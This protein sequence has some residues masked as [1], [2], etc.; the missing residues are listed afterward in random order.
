MTD[1]WKLKYTFDCSTF[2]QSGNFQ[3]HE[4]GG[5]D[6][7]WSVNDPAKSKSALTH[8]YDDAGSH[9]LQVNSEY[10]WTMKVI[11]ERGQ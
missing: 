9:Y 1:T 3:V 5:N 8:A 7:A 11:D 4:D 6:F 2:G 10:A